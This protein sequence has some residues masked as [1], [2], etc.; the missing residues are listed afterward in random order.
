M[1]DR[2][3]SDC[4]A[5]CPSSTLLAA[6]D[7]RHARLSAALGVIGTLLLHAVFMSAAV[8]AL[9]APSVAAYPSTAAGTDGDALLLL[10]PLT[11]ANVGRGLDDSSVQNWVPPR[12]EVPSAD[13]D[14]P[15][16]QRLEQPE[17]PQ[18]TA[19]PV[20]RITFIKTCRETYP[21]ERRLNQ[22]L[23]AVSLQG[24]HVEL[25]SGGDPQRA[26]MA[27]HC[28]QALGTLGAVTTPSGHSQLEVD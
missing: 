12:L 22:D 11:A 7:A 18:H 9:R 25:T 26:L 27:L 10:L 19:T 14:A 15:R 2:C 20:D 23:A 17:A 28:L 24:V 16:I 3:R 5:H 4:R 1:T 8:L 6:G 21:D 13:L